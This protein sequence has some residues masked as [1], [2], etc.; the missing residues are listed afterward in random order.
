MSKVKKELVKTARGTR[1]IWGDEIL[2]W[3]KIRTVAEELAKFYGFKKIETPHFEHAELFEASLGGTTDVVEK[4]M[5]SFRTRGGDR[6]V[7]RPEGTVPSVRAYFENGMASLPQPVMLYYSGSF[8][9]HE[10]PQKGR[11]REFGQFGLEILGEEGAVA[12]ASVIRVMSLIFE[13]LSLA[14]VLELNTIGDKEC[15][16]AYKKELAGHYRKHFN[17]ICKDCKRRLKENPLRLLDCKETSCREIRDKAPQMIEYVCEECKNHF[18]EVLD[19]MDT[20]EI[21][22]RLAPYLV[23]GF[24]YYTRTVF[25]FAMDAT[26]QDKRIELGGGGR[27]DYL[28]QVLASKDLPAAGGGLGIDRIAELLKER[29]GSFAGEAAKVFLIQLGEAAKKKSLKLLEE[30]RK[31]RI[32]LAQSLSK[33][34]IRGQLKIAAKLGVSY[35]LIIGQKEAMDG[36][37]IIRDMDSGSQEA[38]PVGKVIER[39]KLKVKMR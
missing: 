13:E 3:D 30:F 1:D 6:L 11:H 35:S 2:I 37:I 5:Y 8:F 17:Y 24:D 22:Y 4:Q 15:R 21:P 19:F 34:S 26:E 7:L 10:T 18:K 23:R 33:D 25:E 20:L 39:I 9:R 29:G 14:P 28:A 12:D 38:L 32:P 16:P 31:A 27:Y 36:T